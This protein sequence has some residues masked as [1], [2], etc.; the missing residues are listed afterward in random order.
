MRERLTKQLKQKT[1]SKKKTPT[2]QFNQKTKSAQNTNVLVKVKNKQCA[3][4]QRNSES[5]KQIVRKTPT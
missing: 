3:K 1:N 5:R 4:Q 2:Y